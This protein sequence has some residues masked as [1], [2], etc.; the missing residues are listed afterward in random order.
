MTGSPA[1]G[2]LHRAPLARA[3]AICLLSLPLLAGPARSSHLPPTGATYTS[4]E[5]FAEGT[6]INVTT[7][8]GELRLSETVE[9]FPFIWVAVST[10]GTVVKIDTRT[11]AVLG[12]YK[13]S[14]D[15]MARDPSRTTVDKN[16]NVWVSNRAEGN[17]VPT[18]PVGFNN[19][20]GSVAHIGLEQNG[21]CQDRN[22]NGVIDT[23]RG[24]GDIKAWTNTASAD[25]YGGVTTAAD[26]CIIHYTRV[27]STGTRHVSVS[28]TNDVWVSGTGDRDFD[29]VDGDTGVIVR[30]E[31]SVGC[32]GYGG[33]ID[34]NGVIWSASPLL[35]WDTSKPL[36]A[37]NYTCPGGGYGTALDPFG[38]VWVSDF[39]CSVRKFSAAGVLLGTYNQSGYA[40]GLVADR[41]G[42]IWIAGSLYGN[43]VHHLRNNG[44]FVG[45]VA[46]GSGPTGVSVDASGK[47]WATN[48]SSGTVTR[49]DPAGNGGIGLADLDTRYLGGNL[50]NYSD[51][52]GSVLSGKADVGR[53]TLI[54][55]GQA[56]GAVWDVLTYNADV[57]GDASLNVA[58]VASDNR[59][60]FGPPVPVVGGEA[61]EVGEG[62]YLQVTVSLRRA[63]TGESPSLQDLTIGHRPTGL[64]ARP[65]FADVTNGGVSPYA[66]ELSATLR[67]TQSGAPLEGK[68][69]E[70]HA[71][72]AVDGSRTLVCSDTTDAAGVA[73]CG[74]T[75]NLATI[76][77]GL[78]Y[79]A[80]FAGDDVYG[81]ARDTA[82]LA[83]ATA[84]VPFGPPPPPA[85]DGA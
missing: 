25:A 29:L 69:V 80:T 48:Y 19:Y 42:D 55:D 46:V 8:G 79:E 10:K 75:D 12:E 49:I 68:L 76:A 9:P 54:H 30:S 47:I 37:G 35:R 61:L 27:N 26:E 43:T 5:D 53:W 71:T 74:T 84:T 22:G 56:E 20:M 21:Q 81:P 3:L 45:D 4:S 40:Q 34:G 63:S 72:D 52:T 31:R 60:S 57:P 44:T 17:Y 39:C 2:S 66:P 38:N 73:A 13:S 85:G 18:P 6:S 23:S 64:V 14:P 77:R 59:R 51:M 15:G 32:G 41:N 11:G 83:H 28:A 65:A 67:D 78:G 24:Y 70:F 16:G 1:R 7:A 50:Y 33:L 36:T 58:A 62:R 82:P